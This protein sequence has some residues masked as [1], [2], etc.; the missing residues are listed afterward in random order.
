MLKTLLQSSP[1]ILILLTQSQDLWQAAAQ[2]A[3]EKAREGQKLP[4]HGQEA[5]EEGRG[6]DPQTAST[7]MKRQCPSEWTGPG[8]KVK[9]SKLS[10][11]PITLIE[12]DLH[13]IGEMVHDVTSEALQNFTQEN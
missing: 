13:N 1:Q 3:I 4:S 9:A 12:G 8:K 11:D 6:T 5:E 2:E 7:Q 10:I